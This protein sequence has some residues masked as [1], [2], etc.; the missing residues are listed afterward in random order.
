M[1]IEIPRLRLR[2]YAATDL[3]DALAV[4]GDPETMSFLLGPTRKTKLQPSFAA[5][6][7]PIASTATADSP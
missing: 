2:A 1:I 3:R 7:T 5:P 4:L 6:S